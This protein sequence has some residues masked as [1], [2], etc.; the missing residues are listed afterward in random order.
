MRTTPVSFAEKFGAGVNE[1]S[2]FPILRHLILTEQ[3][4]II[5]EA[6]HNA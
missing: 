2:M 6:N 4:N 5:E 3:S 1:I